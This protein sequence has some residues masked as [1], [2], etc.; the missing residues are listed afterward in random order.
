VVSLDDARRQSIDRMRVTSF[1]I[2]VFALIGIVISLVGVTGVVNAAV[3]TRMRELGLQMAL[4]ATRGRI[5]RAVLG[6]AVRL[7]AVGLAIGLGFSL[8]LGRALEAVL[9]EVPPHDFSTLAVV[10]LVLLGVT[11][12]TC[13]LPAYRAARIDPTVALRMG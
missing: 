9:Y 5:I 11:V 12:S 3:S 7:A 2:T 8:V 1:L 4:G 6:Q 10:A 13:L